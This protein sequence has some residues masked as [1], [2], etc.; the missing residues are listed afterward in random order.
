M[1]L[2]SM[3]YLTPFLM[4]V[5]ASSPVSSFWRA[6]GNAISTFTSQGFLPLTNLAPNFSAYG[7][8]ISLLEALSSSMY[9]IF[10]GVL[11]PSSSRTYP[12]GPLIVT[13]LAPSSVALVTAP[14]ATLP[15]PEM[16]ILFPSKESPWA[17]SISDAK[18]MVPKPVASGRTRDPP[19]PQPLPVRTP[20]FSSLSLL[21]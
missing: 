14:H 16:A 10:S 2:V 5:S 6:H 13:T 18:Y 8:T 9:A 1:L 11:I 17:L 21:Y 20:V 3:T 12:S 4:R 7:S 15:K 19:Q